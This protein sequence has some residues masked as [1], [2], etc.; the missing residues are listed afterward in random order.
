MCTV[1][2]V[3]L[4]RTTRKRKWRRESVFPEPQSVIGFNSKNPCAFLMV[5]PFEGVVWNFN[6]LK[7]KR[8]KKEEFWALWDLIWTRNKHDM[9]EARI[10]NEGSREKMKGCRFLILKPEFIGAGTCCNRL[11]HLVIDYTFPD[12]L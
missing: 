10:G 9:A 8:M 4:M 2:I 3:L 1:S 5:L 12:C 11:Q 7:W 6:R